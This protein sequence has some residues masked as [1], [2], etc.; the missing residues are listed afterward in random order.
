MC[1]G[2]DPN[3]PSQ[4]CAVFDDSGTIFATWPLDASCRRAGSLCPDP[5]TYNP[6]PYD[7]LWS[8]CLTCTLVL[9]TTIPLETTT[10]SSSM[11]TTPQLSSTSIG[12][13]AHPIGFPATG[14]TSTLSIWLP[15]VICLFVLG[16]VLI[17]IGQRF[18]LKRG[19]RV[20][21][22]TPHAHDRDDD[23]FVV[24][25]DESSESLPDN[26][27]FWL[28]CHFVANDEITHDHP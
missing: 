11:S 16:L 4:F 1:F 7:T 20:P 27:M 6:A 23:I 26:R 24:L 28:I 13:T 22:M 12:T 8:G 9:P 2:S 21:T 3:S 17:V 14:S 10:T 19:Y 25:A 15:I 18:Y 5:T